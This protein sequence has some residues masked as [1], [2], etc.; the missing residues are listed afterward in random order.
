MKNWKRLL[1]AL[2]SVLLLTACSGNGP[3]SETETEEPSVPAFVSITSAGVTDYYVIRSDTTNS[4]AEIN[5]AVKVRTEINEAT[6]AEIGISTDWEKNPVYDHEII[7]GNTLRGGLDIDITALGETGYII[8]EVDGDIYICGGAAT[9]IQ[10]GVDHFLQ[11]FV[12]DGQDVTVPTGYEHIVYHEFDI[13][14]LYVDMHRVDKSWKIVISE[15]AY[16]KEKQAAETLQ[17]TIARKCGFL[18]DIITGDESV[19]NAF[20]LSSVKPE[21]SGVHTMHVDG[22]SFILRSSA[23]TGIA[24]CTERF[25]D[26]YLSWGARGKFNFPGDYEYLDLG[27]LMIVTYPDTH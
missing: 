23:S 16:P 12:R 13:P 15:N 7:V 4:R 3:E 8:K 9:G 5:A 18:L 2:L 14:A 22:T 1:A 26:L 19:P 17:E 20:I 27:D 10:M 24:G 21:A 6:G 25:I 11:E